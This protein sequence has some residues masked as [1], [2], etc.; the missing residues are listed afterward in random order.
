[1]M[2][3]EAADIVEKRSA[4]SEMF[5]RLKPAGL[6]CDLATANVLEVGS[7]GG[8]LAGLLCSSVRRLVASDIVDHQIVGAGQFPHLLKEKFKRNGSDFPIDRIDFQVAD[9]TAL[10]YKDNLL[11]VVVSFNT[12]EHIPDPIGALRETFRVVKKADLYF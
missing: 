11:D 7:A 5:A 10:P 3:S 4:L 12:F 9:A 8:L 2:Y 1:M 6:S